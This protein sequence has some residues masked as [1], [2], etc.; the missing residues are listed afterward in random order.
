MKI[1][2]NF[3]YNNSSISLEKK[4]SIYGIFLATRNCTFWNNFNS[5]WAENDAPSIDHDKKDEETW[6]EYNKSFHFL[7]GESENNNNKN[8]LFFKNIDPQGCTLKWWWF[9]SWNLQKEF[10]CKTTIPT[11]SRELCKSSPRCKIYSYICEIY[12][13]QHLYCIHLQIYVRFRIFI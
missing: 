9:W 6:V 13:E 4:F 3:G 10:W 11:Y 5:P 2:L 8:K 12:C 1:H 7:N